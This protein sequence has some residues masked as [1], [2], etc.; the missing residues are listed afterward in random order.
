VYSLNAPT[1]YIDPDGHIPIIPLLIV[2]GIVAL[3]VID[4]GWTAYDAYQATTT[5]ADPNASEE[6]KAFAAAD[7]AMTAAFEAAEPDDVL[8]VALP[9]DDFARYGALGAMRKASKE[10]IEFG[11]KDYRERFTKAMGR[12]VR[13]DHNLHHGF[14]QEFEKAFRKVGI[15][16]HD[17]KDMFELP[18]NLHNRTPHGVHTWPKLE[19]WNGRWREFL[20]KGKDPSKKEMFAFRDILAKEFGISDYLGGAP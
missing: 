17:P 20:E 14:P 11:S 16:I 8:P 7:L 5:L 19:Q 9:L 6:D 10:V 2:G 15:D 4:Y 13:P 3:K 1:K 12:S 18:I